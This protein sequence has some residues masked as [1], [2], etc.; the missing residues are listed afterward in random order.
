MT[1]DPHADAAAPPP[2]AL[3]RLLDA[4]LPHVPLDGWTEA[5]FRAALTDSALPEG[6]ARALCPRGGIDLA[7]AYHL[8]GD[9]A[10]VARLHRTNQT[11]L[12]FPD[13]M[14][15]AIRFRLEAVEDRECVRRGTTLFALPQHAAEGARLIWGTADAIWRALGHDDRDIAWYT[16]RASVSAVYAVTVLYWLGDDSE[17]RAQTWDFLSRRI[18]DVMRIETAKRDLRHTRFGKPVLARLDRLLKMVRAPAPTQ[19]GPG[20]M[21]DPHR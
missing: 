7:V 12:S 8:R 17:G 9:A 1:A 16:K 13:R 4:A 21:S 20:H 2:T 18:A 14:A 6:L 5:T 15:Q 3:D 19:D 11:H 10:M